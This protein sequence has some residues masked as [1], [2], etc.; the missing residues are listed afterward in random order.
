M[1]RISQVA[2]RYGYVLYDL[3]R[4]KKVE[5]AVLE[6]LQKLA[7]MI[8]ENRELRLAF[9]NPLIT[10]QDGESIISEISK[11]LK[12]NELTVNFLCVVASQ[13]RLAEIRGCFGAYR[14]ELN[15]ARSEMTAIVSSPFEL[16]KAH[17]DRLSKILKKKTGHNVELETKIDP[18]LLGGLV[19]R[20]GSHMIDASVRTKMTKLKQN[21]ERVA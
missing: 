16:S 7:V 9:R 21:L 4:E 15:K 1:I 10:R 3:A 5:D 12:M 18:S 13:K 8:T 20:L 6:D 17:L 2:R 11:K 19:V 14:A